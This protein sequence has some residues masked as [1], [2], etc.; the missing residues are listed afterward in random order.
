MATSGPNPYAS[1]ASQPQPNV[2]N[3]FNASGVDVMNDPRRS[4]LRPPSNLSG[5]RGPQPSQTTAIAQPK[6]MP[7][8]PGGV[9]TPV[10][11]RV[12]DI[13]TMNTAPQRGRPMDS[14]YLSDLSNSAGGTNASGVRVGRIRAPRSMAPVRAYRQ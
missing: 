12:G 9:M 1:P 10:G 14:G 3:Q 11:G 4:G 5:A 2:M 6:P 7:V 8:G 13:G